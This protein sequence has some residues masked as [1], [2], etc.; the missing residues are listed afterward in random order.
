MQLR[1][2]IKKYMPQV[3]YNV[4]EKFRTTAY[5]IKF[6]HKRKTAVI[7]LIN[8]YQNDGRYEEEINYLRKY[9]AD[10]FPYPWAKKGYIWKIRSSGK[11]SLPGNERYMIHNGKRLYMN[12][13]PYS[14]LLLEQHEHSPHRYFSRN[15]RFEEGDCFVDVGA[16]EGMIS[17]NIVDKASKVFLIECDSLWIDS[18]KKTFEPYKDKVEIIRKFV[19][20]VDDDENIRLDTLLH[21][22]KAPVVLK[23]DVEG[24]E[25][26]VLAGAAKTLERDTTKI[27]LCTYHKKQD[28]SEFEELIK[29]MGY[30]YEWSEGYMAMVNNPVDPEFRKN[31]I[32]AW[33]NGSEERNP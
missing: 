3:V 21:S 24:M 20:D 7:K 32:R 29:N 17:L 22:E 28:A 23:I 6:K 15:F 14:Q 11:Y 26:K 1:K 12:M 9:G 2:I 16:A 13:I 8:K 5:W 10:Y 27:A 19:S 33:K 25:R 4:G 30:N 18:L 31:M